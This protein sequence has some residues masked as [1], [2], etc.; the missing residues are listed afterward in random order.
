MRGHGGPHPRSSAPTEHPLLGFGDEAG[1]KAPV[2]DGVVASEL[3]AGGAAHV[4]GWLG[5]RERP[6]RLHVRNS[7]QESGIRR[8]LYAVLLV[9]LLVG[10]AWKWP[11]FGGW[12]E[13]PCVDLKGS[14][15]CTRPHSTTVTIED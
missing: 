14:D 4:L 1:T 11:H 2:A 3:A 15:A 5:G 13:T 6:V 10:L 12:Q 7:P 9:V 8:V